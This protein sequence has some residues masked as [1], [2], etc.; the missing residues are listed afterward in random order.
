[1]HPIFV[2]Y[3]ERLAAL[4]ADIAQALA[5]LPA[6][7]LDWTPAPGA[8]SMAVLVAH[9]AG[10]ERYWIGEKAGNMPAQRDRAN[11]FRTKNDDA[12]ALLLLLDDSL[13]QVRLVLAGLTLTDLTKP[14][15][16]RSNGQSVDVAWSLWHELEHV[17][18]HVGHIQ[19]TREWWLA[20][21]G[22]E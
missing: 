20:N 8:N 13:A 16:T 6:A 15:G 14:A 19:L 22:G 9:I 10:S 7:A 17:A 2:A 3:L 11:E 18:M 5:G 21:A 1:M 12:E 4:H